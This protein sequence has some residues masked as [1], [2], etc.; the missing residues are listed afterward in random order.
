MRKRKGLSQ[1]AL[2]EMVGIDAKS[3]SRIERGA[4]YPA[5]ETLERLANAMKLD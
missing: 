5:I 2:A 3:L 4:H 1:D